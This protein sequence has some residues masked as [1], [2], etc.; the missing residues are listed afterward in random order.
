MS[1]EIDMPMLEGREER[2]TV[3]RREKHFK[4]LSLLP[5]IA[6]I[7]YDVSGGP[8]GIEVIDTGSGPHKVLSRTSP[9]FN[10]KVHFLFVVVLQGDTAEG[11]T[12]QIK[13]AC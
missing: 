3:R 9:A 2:D 4:P 1:E 11:A 12:L 13:M 6:L 10:S 7:F 5:L 8:F